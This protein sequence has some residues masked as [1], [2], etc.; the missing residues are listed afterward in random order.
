MIELKG[1]HADA[2]IFIDE[3]EEGVVEQIMHT[4]DSETSSGL[5]VRIMPDTHVGKGSV[6]GFSME[7]GNFLNPNMI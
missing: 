6:I 7:L 2:K 4:L 1:K 3:V 5:K